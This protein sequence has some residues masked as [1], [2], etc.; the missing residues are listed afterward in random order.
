MNDKEI[1]NQAL[2]NLD[3]PAVPEFLLYDESF[4]SVPSDEALREAAGL[5]SRLQNMKQDVALKEAE[6]SAL[7][8]DVR[9]VEEVDLPDKLAQ[10]GLTMIKLADGT[11]VEVKPEVYASIPVDKRNAAFAWLRSNKHGGLIKNTVEIQLGK[12]EDGKRAELERA[13]TE[14]G[15]SYSVAEGVHPQTLKAFVREQD[16]RGTPVPDQFFSVHRVNK[17]RIKRNS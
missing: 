17:A 9:Q 12:G 16:E 1:A 4:S 5:A 6:L 8:A 7:Q 13:L 14:C 2:D 15:V 3:S 11:V 10:L